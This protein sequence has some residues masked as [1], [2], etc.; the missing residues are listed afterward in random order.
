S[1]LI[2]PSVRPIVPPI[3]KPI[4][5]RQ[6]LIARCCHSSPLELSAQKASITPS[7]EGRIRLDNQPTD[8]AS[9]QIATMLTGSTQGAIRSSQVGEGFAIRPPQLCATLR[10]INSLA[11]ASPCSCRR[12]GC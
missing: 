2:S 8:E 3:V 10:G 7:G 4:T 12:C 11:T 9:C 5:A 1:P 6:E